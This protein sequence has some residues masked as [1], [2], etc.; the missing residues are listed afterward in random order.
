M[1]MEGEPEQAALPPELIFELDVEERRAHQG[2]AAHDADRP[3]C[4]TTKARRAFAGRH[5]EVE[6]ARTGRART[7]SW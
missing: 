3:P 1:R 6:R 5:L 2:T 4:S 7:A